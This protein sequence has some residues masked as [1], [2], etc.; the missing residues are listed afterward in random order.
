[1]KAFR[2]VPGELPVDFGE[3]RSR[4]VFGDNGTGKSTIADALEWYF[5]GQIELLSHEGRQQ[6][7]RNVTNGSATT[8]VEVVTNGSLGGTISSEQGSPS[9][10]A[11][12]FGARSKRGGPGPTPTSCRSG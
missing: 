11:R 1:M 9:S 8:A 7:I 4:A 10:V 6:A 3:G 5:T 2:G 12:S